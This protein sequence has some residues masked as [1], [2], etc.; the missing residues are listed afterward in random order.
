M[1]AVK[2]FNPNAVDDFI[3]EFRDTLEFAG[4]SDV[5]V[6]NWDLEAEES[7]PETE[8]KPPAKGNLPPSPGRFPPPP[9][10]RPPQDVLLR[11]D[12]F[13]LTEGDVTIQWPAILAQESVQDIADWLDIVKRKIGRSVTDSLRFTDSVQ[14]EVKPK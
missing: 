2:R 10:K 11:H 12:V 4:L 9:P 7:M 3:R 5:R 8:V 1:N 14:V 13:S 6:I